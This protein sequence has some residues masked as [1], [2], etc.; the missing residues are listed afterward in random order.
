MY[1]FHKAKQ[2][3]NIFSL[4]KHALLF[5]FLIIFLASQVLLNKII[6]K[7]KHKTELILSLVCKLTNEL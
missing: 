6:T 1:N 5:R 3:L 7:L 4:E 2:V